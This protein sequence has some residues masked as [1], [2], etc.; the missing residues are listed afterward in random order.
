MRRREGG[1]RDDYAPAFGGDEVAK[2]GKEDQCVLG[3]NGCQMMRG[4]MFEL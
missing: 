2:F 1:G 4:I 3:K